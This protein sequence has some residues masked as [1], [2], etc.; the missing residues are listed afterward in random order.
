MPETTQ[1]APLPSVLVADDNRE[2]RN[3]V[4][5]L[6]EDQFDIVGAVS[7]GQALVEAESKLHPSI[8]ILDISMPIMSGIEAAIEM[9]KRGSTMKIVFLTVNEDADFVTAALATGATGYVL[10]RNMVTDLVTAINEASAGRTFISPSC[11]T[12]ADNGSIN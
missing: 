4:V 8:G 11:R 6:L 3:I 2:M 5:R 7:D 12:L 10:K 9:R 1:N